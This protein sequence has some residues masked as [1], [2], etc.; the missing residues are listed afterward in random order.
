VSAPRLE[1]KVALVTGAARGL[2]ASVARRLAAQGAQVAIADVLDAAGKA[3]AAE[4]GSR[5]MYVHLDVTSESEWSAALAAVRERFGAVTVLV[6][7]A[8]IYRSAPFEQISTS[9][10]M[11]VVSINQL[12]C[13][14]G[15]RTCAAPMR[16]AGGGSIVNVSST[17][18]IEGVG[19]ALHYTASKHAVIGMTKV[20]AIELGAA[21]IRVNAVCPGAMATP[22]LAEFFGTSV[23]NLLAMPLPQSP[24]GRMGA[25]DEIAATVVFLASDEASYTTGSSF[26]VDGGLTAGVPIPKEPE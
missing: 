14:L 4:L 2:G 21:R 17:A 3:L 24:L 1:G 5:V 25:A 12:G 11:K 23:E 9:E 19:G 7:N 8:G 6:N 10:Y 20:A 26:V 16:A 13:F 22:L 18:G 15:M